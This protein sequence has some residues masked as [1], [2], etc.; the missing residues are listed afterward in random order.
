[1][2]KRLFG[3][4]SILSAFAS[5]TDSDK[6]D[7]H[8]P[9]SSIARDA[10]VSDAAS[11]DAGTN[12]AGEKPVISCTVE[13]PTACVEPKPTYGDIA[14]I[15]KD[16]CVVCHNGQAGGPW[17]LTTYG[18][19]ADWQNE[20]RQE[21]SHCTMPPPDAGVGISDEDRTEILM[22]LRCGLAK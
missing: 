22:W 21:V 2:L 4:L 6:Q 11:S 3:V 20:I 1:M 16:H 8:G 10:A 18:H 14:P 17:P 7:R 12:D 19:V 15:L 9:D 5:C 13:A